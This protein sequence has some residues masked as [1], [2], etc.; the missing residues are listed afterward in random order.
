VGIERAAAAG[1]AA[2]LGLGLS[3]APLGAAEPE[4]IGA[5][6]PRD[7]MAA[8]AAEGMVE[9]ADATADPRAPSV[10]AVRPDGLLVQA[11]FF[12]CEAE[13]CRGLSLSAPLRTRTREQARILQQRVERGAP[14]FDAWV[15]EAPPAV[16]I[17]A[18]LVF[19]GGVSRRLLPMML[20]SLNEV[21]DQSKA[22]QLRQ[23]PQAATLWPAPPS[24]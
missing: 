18:Y 11:T 14:G 2:A 1:R 20:R 7:V 17:D 23:D 16:I 3:A 8:F 21:L 5:V 12:A 6:S 13:A 19:D 10:A 4:R 22:F 9:V 15:S 24:R